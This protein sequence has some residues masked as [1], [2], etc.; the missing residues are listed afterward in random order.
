MLAAVSA[1]AE[2]DAR[3][4][5]IFAT[6]RDYAW[7]LAHPDAE[8]ETAERARFEEALAHRRCGTP[9]QYI[10]GVQEF[11]GLEFRVTPD[12]LI[13]RPETEHLVEAALAAAETW[14][15]PRMLDVG[16]G[17]GAIAVALATRLGQAKITA[18]DL[19]PAA[20]AVARENAGR[21]GVSGQIRFLHSDLLAA[22]AGEQFDI[23][24]SNPPYIGE[25]ERETLAV[26][27]REHEPAMALFSGSTGLEV[28]QRLIPQAARALAP[29]G[30]LLLE[31]GYGQRQALE[32]LLDPAAGWRN[33]QFLPDLQGV[34][35]VAA[36][37]R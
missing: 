12:V 32:G 3:L 19:S 2:Q 34:D 22:V 1:A 24:A 4:L 5:L 27:V 11:Y 30:L 9:M 33:V 10:T 7:L 14:P 29:G 37:T 15:Q 20:L 35:R 16:T 28:Y 8:L 18:L 17:S 31:I 23:I 13:P 21:L 26:Q 25:R 36:A 6:G